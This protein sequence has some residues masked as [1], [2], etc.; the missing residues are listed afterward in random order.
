MTLFMFLKSLHFIG[1]TLW[2]GGMCMLGVV[3]NV[4][5]RAPDGAG[6]LP[7]FTAVQRWNQR[8]VLLAAARLLDYALRR[9]P[10]AYRG[11]DMPT[12]AVR[13]LRRPALAVG[14]YP[15]S[16]RATSVVN[17]VVG[18]P[19]SWL[20]C[21]PSS[22]KPPHAAPLSGSASIAAS[23]AGRPTAPARPDTLPEADSQLHGLPRLMADFRRQQGFGGAML[24]AEPQRA[25]PHAEGWYRPTA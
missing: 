20:N 6:L 18:R 16:V 19:M 11:G 13:R 3:M 7:I 8:V 9:P 24:L 10:A 1:M 14:D 22:N 5:R 23:G 15:F 12:T 25:C 4:W 2:I 21:C 17:G